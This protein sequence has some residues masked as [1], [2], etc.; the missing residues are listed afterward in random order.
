MFSSVPNGND[1][2][3]KMTNYYKFMAMGAGA[4]PVR[5]LSRPSSGG[6]TLIVGARPSSHCGGP[7]EARRA[8]VATL[9]PRKVSS[10]GLPPR[11]DQL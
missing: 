9:T 3:N 4:V 5:Q 11:D 1:L 7:A 2:L 8:R 10:P 6:P